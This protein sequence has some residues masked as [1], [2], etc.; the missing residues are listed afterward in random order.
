MPN[1]KNIKLDLR[2]QSNSLPI[3]EFSLDDMVEDASIV[4]IAKRRSGKSWVVRAILHHYGKNISAGAIISATDRV[5]PFYRHFIP[6][7]YIHFEFNSNLIKRIFQRQMYIRERAAERKKHGKKTNTKAFI[8]MDDCLADKGNWAKDKMIYELLFNGRHYEV[9]YILTM[10]FPL[11][12]KPELRTNFD[13][14]FLLADDT[15]SNQ[16]RIFDHYAGMFPSFDAFRQVFTQ[17]TT[18]HG[19]M[20]IKNGNTA[21]GFLEKVMYY[22]APNLTGVETIIGGRQYNKFHEDNYNS[23][24]ILKNS[25]FGGV[26]DK[27]SKNNLKSKG[28]VVRRIK[29]D[30]EENVRGRRKSKKNRFT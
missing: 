26:E 28:V 14:I 24:W 16:K 20:V 21:D 2:G 18:D 6:D 9:T 25:L 22:K 11:G 27:L 1:D 29:N 4:M 12:I 23:K 30:D 8:V 19:C 15:F 10:Q 5:N 3:K 7:T 17:L 13:Y